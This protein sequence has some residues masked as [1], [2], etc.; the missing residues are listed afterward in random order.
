MREQRL[1]L[2][3]LILTSVMLAIAGALFLY[4]VSLIKTIKPKALNPN[5]SPAASES[6]RPVEITGPGGCIG[7][8]QCLSYC[9]D[10]PQECAKKDQK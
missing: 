5:P 9:Q 2:R 10:H 4:E 6:A 3:V 7:I 8:D 1:F